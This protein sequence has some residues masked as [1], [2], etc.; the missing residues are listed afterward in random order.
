LDLPAGPAVIPI[1]LTYR[2]FQGETYESNVS[3][4]VN[5]EAVTTS[6]QLTVSEYL[7]EPDPVIPGRSV[8][9][10]IV[11]SNSGTVAAPQALLR[12][13]GADSILL[14][15]PQGDSFPLGDL[16]A[17]DSISVNAELVVR[18]DA[19]A[20]PQAQPYTLSYLQGTE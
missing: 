7:T 6:T 4:S 5:V 19:T 15:G 1:K 2:D 11:V 13:S 8:L 14:A 12:I 3:F 20:G 10:Q 17:G 9:V 16:A 18:A